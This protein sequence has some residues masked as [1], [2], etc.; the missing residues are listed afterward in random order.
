MNLILDTQ[1]WIY[2]AN[3]YNQ[4]TGKIDEGLHFKLLNDIVNLINKGKLRLLIIEVIIIEW[5][6]NKETTKILIDKCYNRIKEKKREIESMK[7]SLSLEK[8]SM[9]D[10]IFEEYKSKQNEY[11]KQNENHILAVEDLLYNKSFRV[12]IEDSHKLEAVELALHKKAPFHRKSNSVGDAIILLST[13]DYLKGERYDWIDDSIFVSNNSDDYCEKIGSN[14]IHPELATYFA[15]ASMKFET[16]LARALKL[17]EN[18][19][20]E[21]E[22]FNHYYYER[23]VISCLMS[24]KGEDYGLAEVEFESEIK[25]RLGE[26]EYIYN[27]HQLLLDLGDEFKSEPKDLIALENQDTTTIQL[28]RCT[29]CYSL[30]LRCECGNVHA[31]YDSSNNR[32]ECECGRAYKITGKGGVQ[33]LEQE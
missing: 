1:T 17:S 33:L 29:F 18:I 10:A 7:N 19:I 26:P 3:G 27:P 21:I 13:A 16:N 4:L 14:K 32:I 15:N 8:Q 11:I 25:I 30:H 9:A 6:R 2:L 23:D 28:G 20:K 22:E 24:C 5:A 31:I 12:P